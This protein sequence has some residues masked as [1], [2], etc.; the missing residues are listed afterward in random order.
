M[1][2]TGYKTPK[3]IA[4][5]APQ[6][7]SAKQRP[8]QNAEILRAPSHSVPTPCVNILYGQPQE[9]GTHKEGGHFLSHQAAKNT[10]KG[11]TLSSERHT[12]TG[13]KGQ[14]LPVQLL[15]T[16]Q[17]SSVSSRF[18]SFCRWRNWNAKWRDLP[19][20]TELGTDRPHNP[21]QILLPPKTMNS[22]QGHDYDLVE[23]MYYRLWNIK[24]LKC[25]KMKIVVMWQ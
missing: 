20:V 23:S 21:T 5:P 25:A 22:S 19:K 24:K 9:V 10:C 16:L 13:H 2:S 4:P 6:H 12:L 11:R 14:A 3:D 18:A 17:E 15:S 8:L 7:R 1:T